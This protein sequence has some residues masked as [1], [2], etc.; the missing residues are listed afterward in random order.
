M[1]RPQ[2]F[3][4]D[5]ALSAAMRVFWQRGYTA[6]TIQQLLQDMGI[7]RGS[8][9]ASFGGK[10]SLFQQAMAFYDERLMAHLGAMLTRARDPVDA[11][12]QV[13]E[14]SLLNMPA[15]Q[16]QWG[17]LLVNTVNELAPLEQSLAAEARLRLDRMQQAFAGAVARAREKGR[18]SDSVTDAQAAHLLMT[19]M[20]GLRVQ[21]REGASTETL[22]QGIDPLLHLLFKE[23]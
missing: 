18:V 9:Y 10:R 7:N 20:T 5:Q 12:R 17:C 19:T 16:R 2:A 21:A 8:L 13:F 23:P 14:L 11:I 22:R 15:P 1:A 3:D 6:S 4:R